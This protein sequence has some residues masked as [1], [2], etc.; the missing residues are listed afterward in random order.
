[1]SLEP[2]A[3]VWD[4][5]AMIPLDRFRPLCRKQFRP[6]IEYALVPWKGRSDK[7][8]AHYFACIK[9]GWDNLPE[10]YAGKF[11]SPEY[12]R[13]WCLVKEGYADHTDYVVPDETQGFHGFVSKLIT[14]IR[15]LDPRAAIPE[16]P[17]GMDEDFTAKLITMS[18]KMDPYAVVTRSGNVLT[19]WTAQSQDHASMGHDEFQASKDKVL[20]RIANMIGIS[21][22]ELTKH[23]KEPV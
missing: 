13:K 21:V 16:L 7:S 15:R 14:I 2:V 18:R 9:T 19:I 20:G 3:F 22:S 23:G 11:P 10:Q 1:M 4:G 17:E 5:A 8:H 12:L 6:G